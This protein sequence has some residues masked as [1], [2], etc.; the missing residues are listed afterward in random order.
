[1]GAESKS[2]RRI[3]KNRDEKWSLILKIVWLKW[4][5]RFKISSTVV[6][7]NRS[8][9]EYTLYILTLTLPQMKRPT[10]WVLQMVF[11]HPNRDG[12]CIAIRTD[13]KFPPFVSDHPTDS[14]TK[15]I[16]CQKSQPFSI[17]LK[18]C[19]RDQVLREEGNEYSVQV[20]VRSHLKVAGYEWWATTFVFQ[21]E[22]TLTDGTWEKRK[23]GY[24]RQ[25]ISRRE[26]YSTFTSTRFIYMKLYSQWDFCDN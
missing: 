7:F 2:L 4:R 13:Q 23:E 16:E 17:R 26:M 22:D 10:E 12:F 3:A 14:N 18:A 8:L 5:R 21:V 24:D 9:L 1:M 6:W 19:P 20:R 15:Y 25:S 11:Q